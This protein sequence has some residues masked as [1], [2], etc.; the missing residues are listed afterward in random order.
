[1][2]HIS[3]MK[4]KFR[5]KKTSELTKISKYNHLLCEGIKWHDRSSICAEKNY[6]G[7]DTK[8]SLTSS[9]DQ[10]LETEFTCPLGILKNPT[11]K[12]SY[13]EHNHQRMIPSIQFRSG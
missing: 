7:E 6:N 8:E 5:E 13:S 12:R 3:E 1:M 9:N 11:Y 4:F 10:Q 2:S